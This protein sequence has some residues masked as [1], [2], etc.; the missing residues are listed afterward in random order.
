MLKTIALSAIACAVALGTA[1]AAT[2]I[3]VSDFD[4]DFNSA[5]EMRLRNMVGSAAL[6]GDDELYVGENGL[7]SGAVRSQAQFIYGAAQK[8]TFSY[9]A[10][11]DRA[12]A[13][14]GEG[15]SQASA[16]YDYA[17]GLSFNAIEMLIT[18]RANYQGVDGALWVTELSVN[19]ETFGTIGSPMGGSGQWTFK[20][21]ARDD[22]MVMGV[23]NRSGVFASSAELN[24]VGFKAGSITSAPVPL[25]AAAPLLLA[26]LAGLAG[27]ARRRRAL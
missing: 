26:G 23:L 21:D 7:G 25:P 24:K 14:L 8:F 11:L 27:L 18:D 12:T 3:V 16:T 13:T 15:M 17:D 20:F 4:P 1:N 10:A 2:V 9:D 6:N 5:A 22:F 19:G